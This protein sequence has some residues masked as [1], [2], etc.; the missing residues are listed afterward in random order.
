VTAKNKIERRGGSGNCENASAT[1]SK[2]ATP[3]ALSPAPL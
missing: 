3:E 2:P 1:S